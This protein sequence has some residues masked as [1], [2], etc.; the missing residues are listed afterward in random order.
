MP[1][2][3]LFLV[4]GLLAAPGEAVETVHKDPYSCPKDEVAVYIREEKVYVCKPDFDQQVGIRGY[5]GWCPEGYKMALTM[6]PCRPVGCFQV[7]SILPNWSCPPLHH[8]H[9]NSGSDWTRPFICVQDYR[10]G[11]DVREAKTLSKGHCSVCTIAGHVN[12]PKSR[13]KGGG[14]GKTHKFDTSKLR[15][16]PKA[17][18]RAIA[19]KRC[20]LGTIKKPSKNPKIAYLCFKDPKFKGKRGK[21]KGP[22]GAATKEEKKALV[23]ED[24]D[25]FAD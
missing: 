18:S 15:K 16:S 11:Y 9:E 3:R 10:P 2:I 24:T 17:R 20:P 5:E 8:K 14:G 21:K 23:D 25:Q 12:K 7:Q 4:L 1:M 22:W 13:G 6:D 19:G